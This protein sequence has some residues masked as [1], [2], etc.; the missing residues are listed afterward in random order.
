MPL[1]MNP[2]QKHDVSDFPNVYVPLAQFTGIPSV[3]A[4]H[5]KKVGVFSEGDKLDNEAAISPIN[6]YSAYTVEGLRA[7]IDLDIAASGHDTAY[8]ST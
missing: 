4:D 7:G 3:G 5:D 8:D 1:F 6:D 2:F